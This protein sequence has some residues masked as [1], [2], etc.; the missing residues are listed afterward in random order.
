MARSSSINSITEMKILKEN[1]MILT[2]APGSGKSTVMKLLRENGYICVNEPARQIISEQRAINGSGVADLNPALFTELMLARSISQY[3]DIEASSDLVF[4]DRGVAD[5][6]AYAILYGLSF[7][8]G[9]TAAERYRANSKVFLAPN[10]RE[11][12]TTDEER[13]MTFDASAEMGDNLR[14]IYSKLGYQI[15]DLPLL[16]PEQ[17][18]AFMLDHLR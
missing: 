17:R 2:G 14:M 7:E 3:Q 10:W 15:I 18:V 1:C 12:Y 4:F 6:I 9:W 5:N 13:T 8:H 11:I 16:S